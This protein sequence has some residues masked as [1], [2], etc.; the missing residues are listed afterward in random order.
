MIKMPTATVSAGNWVPTFPN[1]GDPPS[2][3]VEKDPVVYEQG[4]S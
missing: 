2:A 4:P 1:P 3:V